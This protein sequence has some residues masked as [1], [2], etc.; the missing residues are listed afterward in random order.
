MERQ[1]AAENDAYL[2]PVSGYTYGWLADGALIGWLTRFGRL[3][4]PLHTRCSAF[5]RV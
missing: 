1:K 4:C 5:Y 2:D 3:Q